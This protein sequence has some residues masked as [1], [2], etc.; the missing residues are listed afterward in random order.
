MLEHTDAYIA[1][2]VDLGILTSVS[3]RKYPLRPMS[4]A[5][6]LKAYA[7]S[8]SLP[9]YLNPMALDMISHH[10]YYLTDGGLEWLYQVLQ[11]YSLAFLRSSFAVIFQNATEEDLQH[12]D[13]YPHLANCRGTTGIRPKAGTKQGA[14]L[15]HNRRSYHF[16]NIRAAREELLRLSRFYPIS[17]FRL[18]RITK[19]GKTKEIPTILAPSN[20]GD[21]TRFKK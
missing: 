11:S 20:R 13:T 10:Q 1:K 5:T 6:V 3:S 7:L 9:Y 15:K 21:A 2:C 16:D 14:I 17:E 18:F 12:L 4:L 19:E 8:L